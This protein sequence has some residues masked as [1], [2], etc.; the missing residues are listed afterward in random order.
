MPTNIDDKELA[1]LE[2]LALHEIISH[3]DACNAV[4]ALVAEVRRLRK[5]V[6]A[7]EWWEEVDCLY[8]NVAW[9]FDLRQCAIDELYATLTAAREA[10]HAYRK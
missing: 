1:R 8:D 4:P 9:L 3:R 10:V 2:G 5:K 7:W 6:E